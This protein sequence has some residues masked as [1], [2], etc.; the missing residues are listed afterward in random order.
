M[1]SDYQIMHEMAETDK[2]VY[3]FPISN[4][5]KC[6]VGKKE[7]GEVTIAVDNEILQELIDKKFVGGL[8]LMNKEEFFKKIDEIT[9]LN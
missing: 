9:N 4:V 7:W 3:V 8:Y 5:K 6:K 1:L 2:G